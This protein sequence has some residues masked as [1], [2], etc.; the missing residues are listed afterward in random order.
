M[1]RKSVVGFIVLALGCAVCSA[2][3]VTINWNTLAALLWEDA[4]F[5][6]PIT[7]DGS[8]NTVGGFLQLIYLGAD[9]TYNGFSGIGG[10][11]VQG[12][13][14]VLDKSWVGQGYLMTPNGRFTDTTTTTNAAGSQY[15]IRFFEDPAVDW[16]AGT[17]PATGDY[18]VTAN[19]NQTG[20]PLNP[21]D[22]DTF[23]IAANDEADTPVPEPSTMLLFALGAG[24]AAWRRRKN[25]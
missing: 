13:D 21:A 20:S 14:E 3:P 10:E 16:N 18:G 24:V 8:D 25:S 1:M 2:A 6:I 15:V 4:G 5:T 22:V 7:G 12:D 17:V 23:Q 19:F 9:D 11:G